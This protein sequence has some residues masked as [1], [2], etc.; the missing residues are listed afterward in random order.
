MPIYEGLTEM[1]VEN[2][3][4]ADLADFNKKYSD[5]V[6]CNNKTINPNNSILNCT[7]DQMSIRAVSD[8]RDIIS[9]DFQSLNSAD[10]VSK[11]TS[12]Q[13]DASYNYIMNTY[14][15]VVIPERTD[16]DMKLRELNKSSDT[17]AGEQIAHYDSVFYVGILWS[18]AAASLL[19]YVVT[20]KA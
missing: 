13:Y 16:L 6:R 10:K 3:L 19:F 12:S 15:N 14:N 7:P 2:K 5:Y 20:K 17:I 4:L 1:D 18:V 11:I 9:G 8:A